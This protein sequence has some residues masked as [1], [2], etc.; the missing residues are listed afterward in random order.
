MRCA[1]Y[2]RVSTDDQRDNGYSI[3]SQLRMIKEY[4]EKNDY[5][6][7]DVY[8]DAG[9]SG[10]DL[11]RPEMQRL[12]ADIKLKKIDKLVAIKVDRL[13]R[14]NYDGFWLLNYCEEHDV[15]IE[16]ILEPYDVSTANGEMIFGMNL[17]FGQRE[18]KEIGARTKRAMEEMALEHIHPSKA[19]YGYIRNKDTGHLE[20]E[21]IEA[22]VVKEIFKLCK[23]GH[24]TR[25]IATIMK[26]NNAYLKT[27]KWR[28]DRVY[29]ILTNS[30]YIGIFEYGKYK[31]KQQDILRVKD[32]C[33]PIIDEITWN[34]TRNV[35]VKNKHPNYGE[36]IHLFSGLVKCPICGSIMASSESFKYSNGKQK[37]YYHLRCKNHNCSGY[38]LHYNTEKIEIKLKRILEELTIFMLSMDNEI[39]TCNSTKSSDVKEI[40]KAIEKLKIQ[41]K[42]LVDLYLSST[43]DVETINHK[44]DVIK[45]EI[46]KLNKKKTTLDPDNNSKEYTTE[47]I[48]KL[49]CVEKNDSLIFTNIKNIEF[50]FLYDLLSR[51]AKRDM[52]HRLI[53]QIE[54]T[55][56]NN[57]N[58]YIKN[59]KF[60]GE[61]IT[62]SSKEYLKYLNEIMLNN[63]IGIKYQEE[64]DKEKLKN[65]ESDYDVLSLTKM[66]NNVYSNEFIE[67]FISK[68]RQHL[69]VDGIISCSYIEENTIKDVLIL[70]PKKE[71][72]TT[73]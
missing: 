63:N 55:R 33:E 16:L 27:G 65:I 39:I 47:L 1:V 13:T 38:G 66:K 32:Y 70:V 18:R 20:V 42:K 24:S 69:Y 52:I 61:F 31:R 34:A 9:H 26:E 30:I 58:I 60:T 10:K 17:V 14:N 36:F 45:K 29:K 57:F 3:D 62:K 21:P 19:P 49:D 64:I 46:E 12:L 11:M 71:I 53:S 7:V 43:L 2:V 23:E 68:S 25:S 8:N 41:E 56:D 54:I 72:I 51:E 15:K 4:C 50:T 35:L 73:N 37:V 40:E 67:D 22:Q 5:S 6:I 48:K 44:N 28:S 59:I